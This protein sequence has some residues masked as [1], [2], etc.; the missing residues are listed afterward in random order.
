M[1]TPSFRNI[2]VCL[3]YSNFAMPRE[4]N[5]IWEKQDLILNDSDCF[6]VKWR[7]RY[8]CQI[9]TKQYNFLLWLST[10]SVIFV[11]CVLIWRIHYFMQ[12]PWWA[13]HGTSYFQPFR[14]SNKLNCDIAPLR[15]GK[16]FFPCYLV[17]LMSWAK[18]RIVITF[19]FQNRKFEFNLFLPF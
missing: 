14:K 18:P 11:F 9:W 17:F 5:N 13:K 7:H 1:I 6:V 15:A 4:W 10:L 16:N 12:W 8:R 19:L 3:Y 2:S